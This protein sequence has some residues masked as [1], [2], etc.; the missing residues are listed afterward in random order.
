MKGEIGTIFARRLPA[1]A[2]AAAAAAASAPGPNYIIVS[3]KSPL[4]L[5]LR[6]KC[7]AGFAGLNFGL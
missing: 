3:G 7:R 6:A 5:P 2:A 1:A 4:E